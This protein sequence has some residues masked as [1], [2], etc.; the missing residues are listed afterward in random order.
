MMPTDVMARASVSFSSLGFAP[1]TTIPPGDAAA[2]AAAPTPSSFSSKGRLALRSA[3]EQFGFAVV[4]D[5]VPED[6]LRHWESLWAADLMS[7]VDKTASD[8]AAVATLSQDPI[9]RWPLDQ[10]SLGHKFATEYGLP[11]GRLAWAVRRSAEVK[12]VF[13]NLFDTSDLCVSTD[14]VFFN[15]RALPGDSTDH[16]RRNELWPHADQNVHDLP[17]GVWEVYQG[18]MYLWPA[19][20]DSSA[21]VVMPG[22]HMQTFSDLMADVDRWRSKG[23]FCK[24][25]KSQLGAFAAAA[26]R[27]PVPRGGLLL[28]NSRT[29][30]Q[31]WSNGPR[32]A[33]PVCFEPKSR[34]DESALARKRDCVLTGMPTTHW[35]S[36][37]LCHHLPVDASARG[38][39]DGLA[40]NTAA[41]LHTGG[42]LPEDINELL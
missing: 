27:V 30:H 38:A 2:A 1:S 3:L 10:L 16:E 25:P 35:A 21:T 15:N 31:G 7:I 13:A 6:V 36:L 19:N 22:S 39:V 33:V 26:G 18:V 42:T 20:V 23:H 11:Q 12:H 41:H 34:R 9:A 17:A 5:V 29:I 24:L 4:T 37:G 14:N 40:L 28:W 8:P 32:L